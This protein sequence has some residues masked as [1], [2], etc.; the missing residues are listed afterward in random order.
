MAGPSPIGQAVPIGGGGDSWGNIAAMPEF[1]LQQ[2]AI[3][4]P[5]AGAIALLLALR[6]TARSRRRR[7]A[8]APERRAAPQALKRARLIFFLALATLTLILATAILRLL[9]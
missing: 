3:W 4:V 1:D 2:A 7:Q 9:Q 8:S 5:F 6:L